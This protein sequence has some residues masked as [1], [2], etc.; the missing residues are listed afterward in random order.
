MTPRFTAEIHTY[1]DGQPFASVCHSKTGF[2]AD[3]AIVQASD[4]IG[5]IVRRD[6]QDNNGLCNLSWRLKDQAEN[7]AA[8]ALRAHAKGRK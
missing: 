2:G 4:G 1:E 7:A 6:W 5:Q 8:R 3:F